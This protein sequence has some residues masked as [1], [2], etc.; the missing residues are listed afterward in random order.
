VLPSLL[1][2]L[3]VT[4]LTS[5]TSAEDFQAGSIHI[6]D[7]F[8]RALPPI[9][10]NGAVYLTLTNH[11]HLLDQLVGAATPIAEHA[12]IH[13]HRMEDGMVKM[14]KVDEFELPPHEEV[15]FAPG[16]NH[17]MLI[18]L[19]QTLKEG[20]HFPLMLHLKEA[21]HVLVKVIVEPTGAT[22]AAKSE[23]DHGSSAI[24]VHVVIED[25][26]VTDDQGAIKMAQ[27]DN[28][29]LHFSSDETHKL[30][31]HG[32]DIEV[33]VGSG[34]HAM[35]DFDATATGRFPVEIHGSSRHHPLFYLEVYPK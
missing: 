33:E 13:T 25:G 29:T 16:G 6:R 22:S 3:V 1:L 12:E 34:S 19:S 35:V 28:V 2:L 24:Q 8:S 23:H 21:G 7:P 31:I 4:V 17:I 30:H 26:K 15:V 27:G 32:Y 14:R 11:G 9:S 18:G 5:V 20:K 10:K